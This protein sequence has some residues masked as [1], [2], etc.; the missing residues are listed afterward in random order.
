MKLL[1]KQL[2]EAEKGIE[3]MLNAIQMGIITASTKQR[4]ATLEEQKAQL[5][6]Q[7]LQER[8]KNPALS[9]EQIAFFL[10]QYKKTDITD[11]TQRQRLIDCFVN[12]VFVYDDKIV[13]TF[14]YKEGTK[15]INLDDVNGSDM[16][17]YGPPKQDHKAN[18]YNLDTLRNCVV[19]MNENFF[20]VI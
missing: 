19:Q 15:A 3:N 8:I 17:G 20:K 13:L 4:L 18:A 6:E 7:I 12:A 14:N 16:V 2:G 10:D 9:R 5:E 1:Q 11:E